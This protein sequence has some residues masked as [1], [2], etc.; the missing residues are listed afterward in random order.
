[1]TSIKAVL[2]CCAG[3]FAVGTAGAQ[4][5]V[6]AA[7]YPNHSVR[8]LV[9]YTPGG[10]TDVIARI[11]SQKLSDSLGRQ[12]YVENMPG[13]GGNIAT[14]NAAKAA[15]DG[16]A[17]TVVSTNLMVNMS[18]YTRVPYD[19]VKD[20][21]PIT[22]VAYSPN[23]IVV[24]PSVPA[25]S[26]KELIELIKANPGKYSFA[27]PG[28]GSTPHLSGE[29]F[30]Q[31]FA[32]DIVHVP[33]PG[34]AQAISSTI[35][36]HTPIAFTSLP[37]ALSNIKGGQI[38]ALAVLSVKRNAELPDVPT[39]QEAGYPDQEADTLT[40]VLAPA[41]TPKEIIDLL[42]REIAKAVA[43]PDGKAKLLKLGFEPV[44]NKPEEFGAR[45]KSEIE[46]WGKVVRDAHLRIE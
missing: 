6:P 40:G 1:M 24:D 29:L 22:M 15:P 42:Q 11:I 3:L 10:P 35:G 2:A 8:V 9:G 27:S 23:V 39:M 20:F 21:A 7:D 18:L 13:A 30:K 5:A 12:F 14:A 28:I 4:N 32:L 44:A 25:K 34:A 17:I 31:K 38:R 33:F 16:Y 37:P 41:G 46:K 43:Q 36:G 26:V 19:A 45:I